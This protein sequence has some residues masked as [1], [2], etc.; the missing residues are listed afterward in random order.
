M[1]LAN[2][3]ELQVDFE[4]SMCTFP[5]LING[6]DQRPDVVIYSVASH[7][8]IMIELT[9]P[10]E[11]GFLPPKSAKKKG[12]DRLLTKSTPPEDGRPIC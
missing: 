9:V 6:T 8:V 3:W 4:G 1:D 5:A 10:A 2:D 7:V 12:T 11:E